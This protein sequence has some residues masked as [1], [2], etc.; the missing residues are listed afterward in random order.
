MKPQRVWGV[1]C[2]VSYDYGVEPRMRRKVARMV[3]KTMYGVVLGLAVSACGPAEVLQ[4]VPES[5]SP[6]AEAS[7]YIAAAPKCAPAKITSVAD[8]LP[9]AKFVGMMNIQLSHMRSG[10]L[11]AEVGRTLAREAPEAVA[12]MEACKVPLSAV[13]TI[14]L[15]FSEDEDIVV[16]MTAAGIGDPTTLDCFSSAIAKETGSAPWKRETHGCSTEL[17]MPD[18]KSKGFVVDRNTVVLTSSSLEKAVAQRLQGKGRSAA[19]GR[20]SWVRTDVDTKVSMW[21]AM[22]LPKDMQAGLSSLPGLSRV[23]ISVDASRGLGLAVGLGFNSAT[24]ARKAKG[25]IDMQADQIKAMAPVLGLPSSVGDSLTV[26]QKSTR[27]KMGLFLDAAAVEL[28][29]KA[30]GDLSGGSEP[31]QAPEDSPPKRGI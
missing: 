17:V 30:V 7:V 5:A 16:G 29:R 10:P 14:A 20:F 6:Y 24:E 25:E 22:N 27:V 15:G 9:D 26:S 23:S 31:E 3:K 1:W 19:N 12:A 8:A 18:G 28:L 11:F 2:V 4:P 13:D 21:G